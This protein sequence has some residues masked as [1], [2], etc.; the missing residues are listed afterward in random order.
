MFV[1]VAGFVGMNVGG[2]TIVPAGVPGASV[3][4]VVAADCDARPVNA[5]CSSGPSFSARWFCRL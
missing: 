5:C 2:L 4:A 1:P 3:G